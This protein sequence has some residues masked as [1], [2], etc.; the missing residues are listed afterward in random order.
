MNIRTVIAGYN[1]GEKPIWDKMIAAFT[2]GLTLNPT[3]YNYARVTEYMGAYTD[4]DISIIPLV[5]SKFNAMKS[6]LKVLETASKKN[7]AIVSFVNPYLDMPVHYVK[8]Q[9]DWYK[10]IRD[11]VSD[12]D[13][14][15]ESGQNL[16][17]F[18][19]KNYNFDNINLDRKYIY[20]KLCQ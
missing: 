15:K 19:Q 10:H 14:R 5:D 20:S 8:S 3:I 13:M 12:A 4:S 9:K 6:N 2:C 1:D 16:F 11:L 17:D 18:C 7:P